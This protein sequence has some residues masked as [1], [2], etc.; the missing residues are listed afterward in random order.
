M[1]TTALPRDIA[2]RGD[3]DALLAGFFRRAFADDA[4]G[5]IVVELARDLFAHLPVMGDSARIAGPILRRQPGGQAELVTIEPR[6]SG[7]WR[8]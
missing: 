4:L 6:R 5:P 2:G 1:S 7:K 8:P 3:I